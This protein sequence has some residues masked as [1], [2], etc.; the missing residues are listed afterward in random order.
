[1][2]KTEHKHRKHR[3]LLKGKS[4]TKRFLFVF[5]ALLPLILSVAWLVV[6]GIG[7]KASGIALSPARSTPLVIGLVIFIIG[8]VAFLSMMFSEDIKDFYEHLLK[9][10]AH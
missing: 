1:M 2:R 10:K 7:P 4:K 6:L 8:Y 5:T 9:H 3:T